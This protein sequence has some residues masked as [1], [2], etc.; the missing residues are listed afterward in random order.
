M[1]SQTLHHVQTKYAKTLYKKEYIQTVQTLDKRQINHTATTD[2]TLRPC[3][4]IAGYLKKLILPPCV[5]K[6]IIVHT[7]LFSKKLS[8]NQAINAA[9]ICC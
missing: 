8:I 1:V 3:L 5:F 9:K 4:H 2:D 6:N 7:T